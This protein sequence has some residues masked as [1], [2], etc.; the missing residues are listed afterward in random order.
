MT[1]SDEEKNAIIMG[2]PWY[3][4]FN[5]SKVISKKVQG[6]NKSKDH[7]AKDQK[8][9]IRV[10]LVYVVVTANPHIQKRRLS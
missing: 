5:Q 3:S 2:T 7:K 9:D 4:S 1:C 8:R 10:R 6:N